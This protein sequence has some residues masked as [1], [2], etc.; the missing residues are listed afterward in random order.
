MLAGPMSS[1]VAL[2]RK[3]GASFRRSSERRSG[4]DRRVRQI[5]VAIERRIKER[6]Q[7]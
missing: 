5:P 6:R 4:I 7:S 1:F 2:L 3:V